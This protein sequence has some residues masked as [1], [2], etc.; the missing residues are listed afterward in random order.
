MPVRS[1]PSSRRA[2]EEHLVVDREPEDDREDAR[3]RDRVEVARAAEQRRVA[4]E[5]DHEH[6][7]G[8]ADR[9]EVQQHRAQREHRRA[10]Q[11]QQHEERD[12]DER[13]HEP[14][15]ARRRRGVEVLEQHR[16]TADDRVL[17]AELP[18]G[19]LRLTA[20]LLGE[21][22]A[23][24]SRTG[25]LSGSRSRARCRRRPATFVTKPVFACALLVR[26]PR[27]P[28]ARSS[29]SRSRRSTSVPPRRSA[30]C[31]SVGPRAH[32]HDAVE[33][34]PHAAVEPARPAGRRLQ[35]V[36]ERP[37]AAAAVRPVEQRVNAGVELAEAVAQL[38]AAVGQAPRPARR[39]DSRPSAS[40][41]VP[42]PNRASAP[43]SR[44]MPR[45]IWREAS[46]FAVWRRR[47]AGE[48]GPGRSPS[49]M[50]ASAAALQRAAARSDRRRPRG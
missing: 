39:P 32:A 31:W 19:A 36:G 29:R 30:A 35:P 1:R 38:P 20:Q 45:A 5:A 43:S 25:R 9:H 4:A 44:P 26:R 6:A 8:G 27:S 34:P 24:R 14:R 41:P 12:Q 42:S 21:P 18:R 47:G 50:S 17:G 33:D 23:R 22:D 13:E 37:R 28:R 10:E 40:L 46:A 15:E 48:V 7:D 2:D 3:E 16:R 11:Q 49:W